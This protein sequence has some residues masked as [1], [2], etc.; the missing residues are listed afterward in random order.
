V[1]SINEANKY[2]VIKELVCNNGNKDRAALK[3]SCSKRSINRYIAGY[4]AEGKAF[5]EHGNRNRK[6]VH[7]VCPEIVSNIVDLY[8]NKYFDANFAHFTELIAEKEGIVLS[9]SAVRNILMSADILSPMATR[10]MKRAFKARLLK[11]AKKAAPKKEI[12]AIKSKI[13]AVDDA[14]PRRPR[15]AN[16]GEMI[17]MDA[18]LH[19][20]FG[21][22]K[23]TL[24]LAID[25]ATGIIVGGYF[26]KEETLYGYYNVLKQILT[27]SNQIIEP[28][29]AQNK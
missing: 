23:F 29:I 28:R 25:D 24:H 9:E 12:N 8:T 26:D 6:P 21:N 16:F 4:N 22:E 17:Q 2:K 11:E 7:S 18:S 1:L 27:V 3:L 14:H 10:R 15:C 5:F 13:M 19:I 20:W